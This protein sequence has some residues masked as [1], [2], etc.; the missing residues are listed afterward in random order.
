[1][2]ILAVGLAVVLADQLAKW[3]VVH[4][5]AP[6]VRV[7]VLPGLIYFT[8]VHNP[9][10]AFGLFA[11]QQLFLTA[12]AVA[13]L[14]FAWWRRRDIGRLPRGMR[15][16]VSLGLG[17]AVGNLI[18]RL[19]RGAVVDFIDIL[20]LPVF[21]VADMAIVAGVAVL[22]WFVL[23]GRDAPAPKEDARGA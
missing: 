18:D 17:G 6:G 2:R 7:P 4:W 1:M 21:N 16:A 14:A 20:I 9:G 12:G 19:F 10:A 11:Y 15:F 23:L 3:A 22:A 8:R 13:V 5:L